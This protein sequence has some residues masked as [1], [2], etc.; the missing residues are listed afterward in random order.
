MIHVYII[1]MCAILIEMYLLCYLIYTCKFYLFYWTI[2]LALIYLGVYFTVDI[3][4]RHQELGHGT[5]IKPLAL[6]SENIQS[7]CKYR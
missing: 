3:D 6:H 4:T 1:L 7:Q 2:T 5:C